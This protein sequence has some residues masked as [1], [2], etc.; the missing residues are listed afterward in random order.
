MIGFFGAL[1]GL[2]ALLAGIVI[3]LA[4]TGWRFGVLVLPIVF[5]CLTAVEVRRSSR[6]PDEPELATRQ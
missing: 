6:K 1:F 2:S 5:A 4:S 3:Q